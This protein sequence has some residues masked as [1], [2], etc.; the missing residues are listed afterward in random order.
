MQ[1][2]NTFSLLTLFVLALFVFTGCNKEKEE[3]VPTV[4]SYVGVWKLD[5][6]QSKLFAGSFS[7]PN[8]NYAGTTQT[9]EFKTEGQVIDKD[10][11]ATLTT[12]TWTL[13]GKKITFA[14]PPNS[15]TDEVQNGTWDVKEVTATRLV[16]HMRK[17]IGA[18]GSME[19]G[20]DFT[21]TYK[22]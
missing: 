11:S 5:S 1:R 21:I 20:E 13:S 9:L 8:E 18:S 4:Q 2:K 3:V 15:Y 17:V 16:L 6:Y 7:T 10:M 14:F 22:K 19:T 12:G